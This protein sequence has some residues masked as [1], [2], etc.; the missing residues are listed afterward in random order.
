MMTGTE[1][2][3]LK[4]LALVFGNAPQHADIEAILSRARTLEDY[5]TG[6]DKPEKAPSNASTSASKKASRG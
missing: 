3:R 2:I 1:D 5:V 6:Q 4:I